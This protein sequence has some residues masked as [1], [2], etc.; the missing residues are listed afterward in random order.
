M[1]L[2][3]QFSEK[4]NGKF[5]SFDRIIINGYLRGLININSFSFYLYQQG[6]YAYNFK[7]FA[8][9][10]TKEL[11]EHIESFVKD[12]GCSTEYLT[13]SKISKDELVNDCFSKNPNKKGLIAAFSIVESCKVITVKSK[14]SEFISRPTKCKHYYLYFNDD[15]FGRMFIRIQTWF[16]YNV[17]IYI[18]GH[19][20]LAKVFDKFNIKYEMF[21]NSFSYI[22]DFDKAQKIADNAFFNK[23]FTAS[24]DKLVSQINIHLPKIKELMDES[25]YYC[26]NQCEFA[27]DINFKSV[28]D[29]NPIYKKL[30]ETAFFTLEC[31][32]IYSF[33][34]RNIKYISNIRKGNIT[35]DFKS[36]YQGYRIKFK[37]NKNQVKMY[38]KGNNLRIE[39]TINN[40]NDFKV[41]KNI[42]NDDNINDNDTDTDSSKKR[43]VPMAKSISNLYRYALVSKS[44]IDRFIDA[45]PNIDIEN[46]I[47]KEDIQ[48]I[49]SRTIFNDRVYSGF[50]ILNSENIKL[51]STISNGKYTIDGF[52][53]KSIIN[54]LFD[55]ASKKNINKLTR[56]FAKLRAFGIIKKVD[57]KNK[58]FLTNFGRNICNSILL[59]FNKQLLGF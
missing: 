26:V 55:E 34:G 46:N 23:N 14:S 30:T 32:N 40:P 31:D 24:F 6:I 42:S 39:V 16:P 7:A 5:T 1:N 20:Y 27:L 53:N 3:N 2:L 45:L 37:L 4:I 22:D 18:N 25:Y 56:T 28:S 15:V 8:E 54:D 57:G 13:S 19:E 9:A 21:N 35:S 12:N 33:F 49:S 47:P 41:L 58:Y 10:Q 48:K 52:T 59:Y 29:L 50:N 36:W 44:I 51:F 11:C 38:N 43:L 17:E